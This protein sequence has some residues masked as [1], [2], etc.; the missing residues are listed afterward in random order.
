[1]H[2]RSESYHVLMCYCVNYILAPVNSSLMFGD[3]CKNPEQC[4]MFTELYRGFKVHACGRKA[5]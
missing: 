2:S 3:C 1:M 5:C 4:A